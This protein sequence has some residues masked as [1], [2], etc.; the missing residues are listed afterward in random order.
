M[1]SK[2]KTAK[3]LLAESNLPMDAASFYRSLVLIG[4]MKDVE[5]ASTTGSGEMKSFVQ[6]TECGLEY[7]ENKASGWHEFKTEPKF[8]ENQFG[9]AYLAACQGALEHA[10]TLFGAQQVAEKGL[11]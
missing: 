5:Y 3:L 8:Y 6:F 7:G 2:L 11:L 1:T 10:K 9:K 4:A